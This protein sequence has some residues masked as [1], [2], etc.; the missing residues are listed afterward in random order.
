MTAAISQLRT[1]MKRYLVRPRLELRRS[2][3]QSSLF[4]AK[5]SLQRELCSRRLA[6]PVQRSAPGRPTVTLARIIGNDLY[7]R[8]AEGQALI[9]LETVLAH[10]P[11]FPGWQKV[12]VFN[13]W[14][15]AEAVDKAVRRVEA[16]GHRAVVLPFEADLY[17]RIACEP[18]FFGGHHYFQSPQFEAKSVNQKNRERLWACAPKV[19]Y[20]MNINGARNVALEL[21]RAQTDWTFVLDGSCFMNHE[22]QRR[23]SQD[24]VRAPYVPY[25]VLSMRRLAANC[26]L[27]AADVEPNPD[28]EPQL[29]FRFDTLEAFDALFPYGMRDKTALLDRLG[30]PGFWNL[31]GDMPWLPAPSSRARERH[32]YKY[33]S[34]AVLRLTSG[35]AAGSLE[36]PAAQAQ[37]YRSRADA[38]F[39]T[40]AA[41]DDRCDSPDRLQAL[42]LMGLPQSSLPRR[43]ST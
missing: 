6:G 7:P 31:W 8:H 26:D 37:R 2:W 40:L 17:R 14:L 20:L 25:L 16:S 1:Q 3:Y 35:V 27:E 15:D 38:I 22:A 43:G 34:A 30:I 23:I 12:F 33:S 18:A 19:Q 9:N 5:R 39:R 41:I 24:L 4:R 28:E 42:A 32:C 21:G 11:D 36:A 13:R 29:A 10:E